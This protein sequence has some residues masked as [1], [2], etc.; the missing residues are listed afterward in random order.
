[1]RFTL[2]VEPGP[3]FLTLHAA[4]PMDLGDLCGIFALAG[5]IA[6][7]N[8]H[9]RALFD[10]LDVQVDLSFT[11]HLHLGTH[12]AASLVKLERAASVVSI[13]NRRGTSEKAAQKQGLRF[14][15]F[16][17]MDEA[18]AWITEG[19]TERIIAGS[20]VR[21]LPPVAGSGE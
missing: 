19:A 10:L 9:R 12:A 3:L 18:L 13:A 5:S 17:A 11:D 21:P 2:A 8:G 6:G 4:G 14:R 16:T 1:M 15:T 7:I 20:R